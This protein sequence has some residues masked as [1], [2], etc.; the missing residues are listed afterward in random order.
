MKKNNQKT[1]KFSFNI[2]EMS[3]SATNPGKIT[4]QSLFLILTFI[5][6]IVT[7]FI[8]AVHFLK[9]NSTDLEILMIIARH[10]KKLA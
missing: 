6:I 3:F 7:L 9:V 1:E 10:L 8:I 4:F 2:L 5:A